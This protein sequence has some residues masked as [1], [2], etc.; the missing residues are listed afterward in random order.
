[1]KMKITSIL[2]VGLLMI[3]CGSSSVYQLPDAQQKGLTYQ[4]YQESPDEVFGTVNEVLESNAFDIL[5]DQAWEIESSDEQAHTLETGWRETGGSGSVSGG[6]VAGS[7]SDERMRMKVNI[8]DEGSGSK[9]S[10]R[11]QKQVKMS[12][13]RTFDVKKKAVQDYIQPVFTELEEQGLTKQN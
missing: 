4:T 13:W 6:R 7:S 1:M 12:E 3:S 2:I 11:L 9:V 5:M 10:I 8:S